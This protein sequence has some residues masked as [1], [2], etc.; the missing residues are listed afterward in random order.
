VFQKHWSC[1]LVTAFALTVPNPGAAQ[2]LCDVV[3]EAERTATSHSSG[4]GPWRSSSPIATGPLELRETVGTIVE[5]VRRRYHLSASLSDALA[6]IASYGTGLAAN[7]SRFGQDT[8]GLHMIDSDQGTAHCQVLLFFDVASDGNAQLVADP[9]GVDP[10]Q[11]C[12]TK[13]GRAGEVLGTPAFIVTDERVPGN[14]IVTSVTPWQRNAWQTTCRIHFKFSDSFGVADR[15]CSGVDCEKIEAEV[16]R[17][18]ERVDHKTPPA[19]NEPPFDRETFERMKAQAVYLRG[20]L[21]MLPRDKPSQFS[22]SLVEF[23]DD[24]LLPFVFEGKTYLARIGHAAFH[25]LTSR[26][27]LFNAYQLVDD[28]LELVAEFYVDK[29]RGRLLRAT[30]E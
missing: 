11:L 8:I 28:H 19:A 29:A 12:S 2:N 22:T 7:L 17:L 13:S 10:G 26:D 27:Y 20:F 5:H 14:D 15:A 21:D 16:L 25:A 23:R 30:V 9:P 1:A 24:V 18:V 3:A 6:R 4:T